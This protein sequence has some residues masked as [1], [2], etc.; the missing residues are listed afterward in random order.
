[1]NLE[2]IAA[3]SYRNCHAI[4]LDS[5]LFDD[6]P[7]ARAR[8]FFAN[9]HHDL[10]RNHPSLKY[11]MSIALHS[12]HC[13]LELEPMSGRV[14][15]VS[16]WQ[17]KHG[18]VRPPISAAMSYFKYVSPINSQAGSF[19]K[20]KCDVD[21]S[22]ELE[23]LIGP[24]SFDAKEMHSIYV[25]RSHRAA[26]MVR[27]GSEDPN[28]SSMVISNANLEHFDFTEMYQPMTVHYLVEILDMVPGYSSY[29]RT[30]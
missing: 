20:L 7:G 8:M 4:G 29:L 22:T 21:V 18:S 2:W 24:R 16:R 5:V 26:W 17:Y 15:N 28:H 19:E 23:E 30:K 3:H 1:M 9:N 10:W 14:W 27:E 6:T 12:H 13:N 25:Q 11:P